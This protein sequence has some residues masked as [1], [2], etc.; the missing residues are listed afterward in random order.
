MHPVTQRNLEQAMRDEG[1][2]FARYMLYGR[3]ARGNERRELADMFELLADVEV[4][5]YFM[6]EAEL[7]GVGSA[8]DIENLREAVADEATAAQET[9]RLFERQA[10]DVGEVEA[11]ERF[12]RIRADKERRHADLARSLAKLESARPEPHRILV[13]A[14]ESCGGSGLC[15]EV[16]YRAGRLASEVLVVAPALTRSRLHYLASDLDEERAEAEERMETLLSEL[17]RSG[18]EASGRVGDASPMVAIEDALREFPAD[19]IVIATHPADRSTWLERGVV[20]EARRRFGHLLIT[21]VVVDP[22]MDRGA[23][24]TGD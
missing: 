16:R 5:D 17:D 13:V 24:V 23:V 10:R 20:H 19:E 2:A 11:A 15:D 14:N 1:F 9:Y 22:A 4:F 8:S 12:G 18:I 6:H 3:R 21:H 7:A